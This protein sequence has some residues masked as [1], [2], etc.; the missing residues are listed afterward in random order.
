MVKE[1]SIKT[2]EILSYDLKQNVTHN[3]YSLVVTIKN[4]LDMACEILSA[5][6]NRENV[7]TTFDFDNSV[8]L[9][10]S[11]ILNS[12]DPLINMMDELGVK[13]SPQI[14]CILRLLP[15]VSHRITSFM[16]DSPMF[17]CTQNDR[18]ITITDLSV[19][20]DEATEYL[21]RNYGLE[22][23]PQKGYIINVNGIDDI[24]KCKEVETYHLTFGTQYHSTDQKELLLP[25]PQEDNKTFKIFSSETKNH[26]TN[27]KAVYNVLKCIFGEE[28]VTFSPFGTFFIPTINLDDNFT[29][30]ELYTIKHTLSNIDFPIIYLPAK[31][32]LS[33]D[34]SSWNELEEKYNKMMSLGL[35]TT[36][37]SPFNRH[38]KFKVKLVMSD[39]KVEDFNSKSIAEINR[40]NGTKFA[41]TGN[42]GDI[43]PIG[44][45]VSSESTPRYLFFDIPCD[46][47]IQYNDVQ[48]L[49]D[50]ILHNP[51]NE[52]FSI[53]KN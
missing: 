37:K 51:I 5:K 13:R 42:K 36:A 48:R 25:M 6:L 40:L 30:L 34:F 27:A 21:K 47:D 8:K 2:F 29:P 26:S 16:D 45:L 19:P 39:D 50:F 18:T 28:N 3:G 33:F 20:L 1:A 46:T 43:I 24:T 32:L 17:K 44:S 15:C 10:Y 9:T 11:E 53:S 7:E 52:I 4:Q 12:L 38:F 35:F 14:C 23:L 22:P 49:N 31:S 41:I